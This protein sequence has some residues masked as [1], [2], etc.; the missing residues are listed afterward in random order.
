MEV[1]EEQTLSE[2]RVVGDL[3]DDRTS[4][5]D[6]FF[7]FFF[8][9]LCGMAKKKNRPSRKRT[10]RLAGQAEKDQKYIVFICK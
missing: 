7:C 9:L 3:V 8:V 4:R 5:H 1:K 2:R 10:S 6:L